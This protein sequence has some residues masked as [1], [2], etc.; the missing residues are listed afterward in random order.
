MERAS[1]LFDRLIVGV[2]VNIEKQTMFTA[3]ERHRLIRE[4]TAHSKTSKSAPSPGW[5]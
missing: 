2:G 5:R 1:R 4:A 3:D